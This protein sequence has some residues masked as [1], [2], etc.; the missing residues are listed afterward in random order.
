M[1]LD[2]EQ[3]AAHMQ[4]P[5]VVDGAQKLN[6]ALLPPGWERNEVAAPTPG[7]LAFTT[8]TA[9]VDYCNA[10]LEQDRGAMTSNGVAMAVVTTPANVALV[11]RL[12][13]EDTGMRRCCFASASPYLPAL[14]LGTYLTAEAFIVML[15]TKFQQSAELSELVRLLAS[16][17]ENDVRESTDS[18]YAQ[19]VA[20]RSGIDLAVQSIP[21]PVRLAPFRTF[22]EVAQPESLFYLRLKKGTEQPLVSLHEADGG[23][24]R[25][26]AVRAVGAYLAEKLKDNKLVKVLA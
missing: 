2:L 15:H 6:T 16:I 19:K 3:V 20:V 25:P 26:M 1:D 17:T 11:N 23:A 10:G 4:A 18:G 24:W 12:E 7:V 14:E 22:P 8:L 21:N 5:V 9:L 13:G